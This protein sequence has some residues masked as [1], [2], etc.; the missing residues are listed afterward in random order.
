M[1]AAEALAW[2][3]AH[4]DPELVQRIADAAPPFTEAQRRLLTATLAEVVRRRAVAA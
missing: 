1:T 4:G 3:E 2:T